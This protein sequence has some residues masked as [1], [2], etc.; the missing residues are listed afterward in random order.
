MPSVKHDGDGKPTTIWISSDEDVPTVNAP[1]GV[2]LAKSA[3]LLK[4]INLWGYQ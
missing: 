4:T 2:W 1:S 3:P